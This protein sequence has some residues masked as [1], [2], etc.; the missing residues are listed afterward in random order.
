MALQF[1]IGFG[2]S[3]LVAF[4]AYKK[5]SLSKSGF[6]T[7]TLLG[8]IIYGFGT[9]V[10]WGALILFFISSSLLT[11]LH[12]KKVKDAS[13]GRNYIQVL[14]N[15]F[16]AAMFSVFFYFTSNELFMVAAI[17]SIASCNSD[18]WASEIGV[19]SKGKTYS[20][21]TFKEVPKGVSGGVSKLGT[22][23]S[24]LGALFIGI[25]FIFLYGSSS[26]FNNS[27]IWT[28]FSVITLG[29]FIGCLI[30]SYMGILV[31]AKYKGEKTGKY[32]EKG[33]L[34]NEKVILTSGLA[35]ITNDAV[36]F[37]SGFISTAVT[38]LIFV[39]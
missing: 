19:L 17:I 9:Y 25:S 23:A 26:M 14:S 12:E 1:L 38:M 15:G 2:L 4:L 30:D 31:Q 11:K 5:H 7:A 35:W 22:L 32:T 34:E 21:L 29:G 18:T 3:F 37:I 36:N 13:S 39:F 20:I 10:V 8:T 27:K 6:I 28:Y 33:F 16:V 24:F